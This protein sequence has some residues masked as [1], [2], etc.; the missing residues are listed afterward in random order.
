MLKEIILSWNLTVS[1][2]YLVSKSSTSF[3][4]EESASY[5]Q[6][7]SLCSFILSAQKGIPAVATLHIQQWAIQLA[8]YNYVLKVRKSSQ[9]RNADALSRLPLQSTQK[10][11]SSGIFNLG[12]ISLYYEQ[13]LQVFPVTAIEVAHVTER[14]NLLT[15]LKQ[16]TIYDWCNKDE[17]PKELKTYYP[18]RHVSVEQE[19][20]LRGSR[21]V[22]TEGVLQP[23]VL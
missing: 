18:I 8:A 7:I 23:Y 2:V 14:D 19:C 22:K 21:V 9:H 10:E 12:E 17:L 1:A 16:L 4:A 15:R 5:S 3:Y 11:E 6:T 13:R 20:P